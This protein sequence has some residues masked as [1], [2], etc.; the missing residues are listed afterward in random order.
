[1]VEMS[2]ARRLEWDRNSEADVSTL[3]ELDALVDRLEESAVGEP[4]LVELVA[5]DGA[6]LSVGLGRPTTVVNYTSGSLDP[7]YFQSLGDQGDD[8]LVFWY[9]GEWSEFP[10]ESAVPRDVGREA[11]RRFF[12]EGHR[13]ENVVWRE[14]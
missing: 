2:N 3:T 7:P 1:M 11:L 9:R 12:T 14:V 13:P 6:S 8:E 10:P 5:P 4:F